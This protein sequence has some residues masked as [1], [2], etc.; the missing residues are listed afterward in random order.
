M[1]PAGS[2]PSRPATSPP[3]APTRPPPLPPPAR[4]PALPPPPRGGG[5]RAAPTPRAGRPAGAAP[6]RAVA[7]RPAGLEAVRAGRV[8][9]RRD[10]PA[11]PRR[12]VEDQ[13]AERRD[14]HIVSGA[15]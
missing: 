2:R 4:P 5:G 9:V 11:G 1:M 12:D 6:P 10:R 3:R 7:R 14:R 15:S 8:V 13:I